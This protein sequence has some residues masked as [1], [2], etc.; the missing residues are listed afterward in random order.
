MIPSNPDQNLESIMHYENSRDVVIE[1]SECH[2]LTFSEKAVLYGQSANYMIGADVALHILVDHERSAVVINDCVSGVWQEQSLIHLQTAESL[3]LQIAILFR[4]AEVVVG[5]LGTTISRTITRKAELVSGPVQINRGELIGLQKVAAPA[6]LPAGTAVMDFC[7][8]FPDGSAVLCGWIVQPWQDATDLSVAIE[9][10]NVRF[11]LPA[12]VLWYNRPD[13]GNDG[14]GYILSFL[15]PPEV[16]MNREVLSSVQV[17]LALYSYRLSPHPETQ[18]LEAEHA[19]AWMAEVLPRIRKG[20]ISALREVISRPVFSGIDTLAS[21]PV[22]CHLDTDVV[23]AVPGK[24]LLLLGWFLDPM[25]AVRSIRICSGRATSVKDL[26]ASLLRLERPD[27]RAAF[28]NRYDLLDSRLG[29]LAYSPVVAKPGS[30]LH[31]EIELESGEIGFKPLLSPVAAGVPAIRRV[32]ENLKLTGDELQP[33]FD[34]ILGEPLIAINRARLAKPMSVS[35]IRLGAVPESPRCSIV[36]PLYGRLDF[37]EYQCALFSQGGIAQDELIYVLDQPERKAE[38][39][40]L[41]RTCHAKYGLPMRLIL[42]DENRGF[43]PAS[44]LGLERAKGRHVCFLNSDIF[45]AETDWLDRLVGTLEADPGIGTVGALCIFADGSVQH[46]GMDYEPVP[47]FGGWMFPKHPGKGMK[48]PAVVT[49]LLDAP[50]V[51][52]ACMVMRKDLAADLG[53]FD[54]DY[55]IGDF[56]DADLCN[57]IKARGLRC[58]V[59]QEVVLYHLERQSQGDQAMDWRMNLTLLNAW[60]FNGRWCDMTR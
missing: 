19:R 10:D 33:T 31:A 28:E 52:G 47:R 60:T 3:P 23:Y 56:E 27:V 39:L 17:E 48:P 55:V 5:S 57:R 16:E 14:T 25:A 12:E 58:V 18:L 51:T 7:G 1:D 21:L 29:F 24:G 35:E 4:P 54:T 34:T 38:L 9:V 2:I 40:D 6:R 46:A 36:V 32:L 45:P 43:G 11:R 37:V 30:P 15:L 13:L 20:N 41:A 22:P 59:D 42:P 26:R 8:L 53:G 44:N 50:G 49:R